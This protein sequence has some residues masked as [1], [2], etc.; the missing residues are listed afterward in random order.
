M[1]RYG[2]SVIPPF[3]LCKN[4]QFLSSTYKLV[5]SM[6]NYCEHIKYIMESLHFVSNIPVQLFMYAAISTL[7]IMYHVCFLIA[8][9]THIKVSHF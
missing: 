4:F 9:N 2:G 1:L 8:N 6:E 7:H 5:E 3:F